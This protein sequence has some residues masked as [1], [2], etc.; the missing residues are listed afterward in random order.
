[1]QQSN[2]D[3]HSAD[4]NNEKTFSIEPQEEKAQV[5]NPTLPKVEKQAGT[6]H[7]HAT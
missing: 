5:D 1:M 3:G 6:K 2:D 4:S 7:R